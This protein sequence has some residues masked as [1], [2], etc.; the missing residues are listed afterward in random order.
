M[1]SFEL[2]DKVKKLKM[3]QNLNKMD[4]RYVNTLKKI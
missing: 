2:F 1:K 4:I 3:T